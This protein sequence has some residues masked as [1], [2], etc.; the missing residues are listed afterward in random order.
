MNENESESDEDLFILL[1]LNF[2]YTSS[3]TTKRDISYT[4]IIFILQLHPSRLARSV[5][6]FSIFLNLLE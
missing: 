5:N 3:F 6:L 1:T 2:T 4:L